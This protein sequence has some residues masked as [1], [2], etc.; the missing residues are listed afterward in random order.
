[1]D[2]FQMF[3]E[4]FPSLKPAQDSPFALFCL[5]LLLLIPMFGNGLEAIADFIVQA[6]SGIKILAMR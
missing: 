6:S 2:G 4:L 1:L 5:M 3:S